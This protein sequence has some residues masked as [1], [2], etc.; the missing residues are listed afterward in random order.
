MGGC[1]YLLVPSPW[2]QNKKSNGR[3]RVQM[4]MKGERYSATIYEEREIYRYH[5][6]TLIRDIQVGSFHTARAPR[7]LSLPFEGVPFLNYL[8]LQNSNPTY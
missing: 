5:E 2:V 8:A 4:E 6:L 1:F 3:F 7:F